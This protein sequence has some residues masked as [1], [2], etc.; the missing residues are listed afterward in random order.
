MLAPMLGRT[1][2]RYLIPY[3]PVHLSMSLMK[4]YPS[5]QP[6]LVNCFPGWIL[7]IYLIFPHMETDS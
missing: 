7:V 2:T 6:S 1:V 5:V 4:F 3:D